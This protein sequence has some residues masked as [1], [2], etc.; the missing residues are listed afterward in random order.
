MPRGSWA[1]TSPK[2]SRMSVTIGPRA[3]ERTVIV[4]GSPPATSITSSRMVSG[5]WR[6][7]ARRCRRST[8]SRYRSATSGPRFVKPHAM[9]VV[10]PDDDAGQARERVPGDVEVACLGTSTQCSPIWVQ[11]DGIAGPRCGS[12]ASNGRPDSVRAPA[13]DPRVRA[14]VA[15]LGAE[16]FGHAVDHAAQRGEG[17]VR[18]RTRARMPRRHP[19]SGRSVAVS[20]GPSRQGRGGRRGRGPPTIVGIASQGNAGW[21]RATSSAGSTV[22]R[23]ARSI[24]SPRFDRRSQAIAFSHAIESTPATT[25]RARSRGSAGR[26]PRT[27]AR[28]RRRCARRGRH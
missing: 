12:L 27:R 7:R 16:Q 28:G 19:S 23:S 4:T 17:G 10:L 2:S 1:P 5:T 21:R 26:A 25:A 6:R 3:V 8:R 14:E 9:R 11:I 15:A 22:E 18:R 13:H 24:S 20:S